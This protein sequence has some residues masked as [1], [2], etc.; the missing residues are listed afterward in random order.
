MGDELVVVVAR[1]STVEGLKRHP[2]VS[3]RTRR[4]MVEALEVVDGAFLGY[5]SDRYRIV[6]ELRPD[7]IALGYDQKDQEKDLE[8]YLH[9]RGIVVEVVRVDKRSGD[10]EGTS[11]ILKR[12]KEV[13]D[14]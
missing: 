4:E 13:G 2:I 9:D 7:V 1:D 8:E 12:I 3:E 6:E 10:V 11:E 14:S 5:E